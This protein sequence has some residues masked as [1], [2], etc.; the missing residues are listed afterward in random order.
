MISHSIMGHICINKGTALGKR[1]TPSYANIYMA[2][3]EKEALEKSRKQPLYYCRY[4]DDIF[5]VC[6]HSEDNFQDFVKGLN[7]QDDCIKVT[8]KIE[9]QTI[10]FWTLPCS[11]DRTFK[12]KRNYILRYF[13]KIPIP[14]PNPNPLPPA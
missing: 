2:N 1:F 7:S 6:T 5:G 9:D 8:A 13:S 4:L 3:W 11:K 14:N 12:P 10:D